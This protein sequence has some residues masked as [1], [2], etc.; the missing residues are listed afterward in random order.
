[1]EKD[2]GQS[3]EFI[4]RSSTPCLPIFGTVS[5]A[6]PIPSH[7]TSNLPAI[8]SGLSVPEKPAS[9]LPGPARV[10]EIMRFGFP[11]LANVRARK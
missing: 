6:T 10:S 11:G 9:G 3:D 1:M 2:I 4:L 7:A 8:S 5:A